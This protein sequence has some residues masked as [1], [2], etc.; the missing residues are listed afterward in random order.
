MTDTQRAELMDGN[1]EWA[2]SLITAALDAGI[3][4]YV[5]IFGFDTQGD[6]YPYKLVIID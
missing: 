3:P 2:D 5:Q 1:M 4:Y 6:E